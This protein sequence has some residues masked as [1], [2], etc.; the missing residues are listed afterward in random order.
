MEQLEMNCRIMLLWFE[1]VATV[2]ET[3]FL[4]LSLCNKDL[5]TFSNM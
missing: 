2:K 1:T 3:I 4:Y 5:K